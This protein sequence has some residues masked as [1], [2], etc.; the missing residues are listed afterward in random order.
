MCKRTFFSGLVIFFIAAFSAFSAFPEEEIVSLNDIN[1]LSGKSALL[2]DVKSYENIVYE[3]F[4]AID[5]PEEE[6]HPPAYINVYEDGLLKKSLRLD[7][8]GFLS[9]ELCEDYSHY[10]HLRIFPLGKDDFIIS[11]YSAYSD[12]RLGIYRIKGNEIIYG[13]GYNLK[14]LRAYENQKY[15]YDG[16]DRI[17]ISFMGQTDFSK[18]GWDTYILVFDLQCNLTQATAVYTKDNDEILGIEAFENNIYFHL[19][20]LSWKQ[21]CIVQLDKKFRVKKTICN[22]YDK[23]TIRGWSLSSN[24]EYLFVETYIQND[25][26]TYISKYDSEGNFLGTYKISYKDSDKNIFTGKLFYGQEGL[27]VL[28]KRQSSENFWNNEVVK[29]IDRFTYFM[30]WDGKIHNQYSFSKGNNLNNSFAAK[31]D[32]KYLCFDFY[33]HKS[34]GIGKV[35]YNFSVEGKKSGC[36]WV[37]VEKVPVDFLSAPEHPAAYNSYQKL[38][39]A[40]MDKIM[41]K[42]ITIPEL[43]FNVELHQ[44]KLEYVHAR[45]DDRKITDK[46][47]HVPFSDR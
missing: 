10:D 47:P 14:G 42:K 20:P 25:P 22:Y 28:V 6:L 46:I 43:K 3:A 41:V 30:D 38:N 15:C 16:K 36:D 31:Y 9:G 34:T 19:S 33:N 18:T 29:E 7:V 12:N 40:W 1:V 4:I 32:D 35:L 45:P 44:V 39:S 23:S 37:C 17:Y 11:V 13:K 26:S 21:Q 8:E 27:T 2:M 24:E 5:S